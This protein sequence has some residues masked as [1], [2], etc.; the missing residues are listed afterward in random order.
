LSQLAGCRTAVCQDCQDCQD[1]CS[2]QDSALPA[3]DVF[4]LLMLRAG[5]SDAA[6]T[7]YE[8]R[9]YTEN[10][11]ASLISICMRGLCVCVCVSVRVYIFAAHSIVYW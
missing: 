11:K 3:I 8:Q 4:D 9:K 5:I 7:A 6:H 1:F 2:S 10:H